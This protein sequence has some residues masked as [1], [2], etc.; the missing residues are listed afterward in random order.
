MRIAGTEFNLKY[1][2]LEIYFQGCKDH[3]CEGCHNSILWPMEGGMELNAELLDKLDGY[4]DL[5][6]VKRVWLLGGEPTDQPGEELLAFAQHCKNKGME[7]WLWTHRKKGDI[8]VRLWEFIDY[9]KTGKYVK[10]FDS[11][12]EPLFGIK[13]ASL[14]QKISMVRHEGHEHIGNVRGRI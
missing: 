7:V 8:D 10:S 5:P 2:A 11:Y 14:N 13:L 1:N 6:L 3:P 4:L 9:I 12:V